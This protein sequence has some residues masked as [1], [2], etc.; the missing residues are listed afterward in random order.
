MINILFLNCI[1]QS[2]KLT[3]KTKV[4]KSEIL[5]KQQERIITVVKSIKEIETFA[6]LIFKTLELPFNIHHLNF[7]KE[8]NYLLN[9]CLNENIN[10][11]SICSFLK[12]NDCSK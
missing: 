6:N 11:K 2:I 9:V 12:I 1:G 3:S 5:E 7:K 10:K 8:I 4:I